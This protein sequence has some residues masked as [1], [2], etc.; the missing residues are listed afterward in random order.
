MLHHS[1]K[2]CAA[3]QN[4]RLG[5]VTGANCDQDLVSR[6]FC[7]LP[8]TI[9]N[10]IV[11]NIIIIITNIIIIQLWFEQDLVW[12]LK[13]W[14]LGT[15]CV[16]WCLNC[17]NMRLCPLLSKLWFEMRWRSRRSPMPPHPPTSS[18]SWTTTLHKEALCSA[19]LSTELFR[20]NWNA[21]SSVFLLLCAS[22]TP[23]SVALHDFYCNTRCVSVKLFNV[24]LH[25]HLCNTMCLSVPNKCI[26]RSS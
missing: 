7:A 3:Q 17:D 11:I 1:V 9:T 4:G 13:M 10:I 15:D 21:L 22:V 20:P 19:L 5:S 6:T 26:T 25:G 16:L 18:L 8:V 12:I 24:P 2:H 23:K 14:K